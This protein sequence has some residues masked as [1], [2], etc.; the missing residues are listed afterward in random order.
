MRRYPPL[1]AAGTAGSFVSLNTATGT[2]QIPA[3][4]TPLTALRRVVPLETVTV[5]MSTF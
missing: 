5:D 3:G 1:P 4:R 2:A